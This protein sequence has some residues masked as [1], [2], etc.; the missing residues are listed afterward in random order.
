MVAVCRVVR[1]EPDP[2]GLKD[3]RRYVRRHGGGTGVAKMGSSQV[4]ASEA[5]DAKDFLI[6]PEQKYEKMRPQREILEC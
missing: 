2:R 3:R 1:E 4:G 5:L 6:S